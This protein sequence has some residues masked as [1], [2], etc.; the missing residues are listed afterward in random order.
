MHKALASIK[1]IM[2][3]PR[4]L[5]LMLF[6]AVFSGAAE[7]R[8]QAVFN[9]FGV[10]GAVVTASRDDQKFVT[11][12][13]SRGE[14]IFPDLADGVWDIKIEM[15]AFSPFQ[16]KVT[17]AP[18]STASQWELKL[19]PID[20]IPDI[21]RAPSLPPPQASAPASSIAQSSNSKKMPK[22]PTNTQTPY[23]RTEVKA[24]G[25]ASSQTNAEILPAPSTNSPSVD[26]SS[27]DLRQ[28]AAD[29]F[30][31]N[32]TANNSASSPFGLSRSFGNNRGLIR[33]LYN[34]S[35]GLTLGNSA[36]DARPYS[37]AGIH[38]DRP[39][40]NQIQGMFSYGGP[41]RIPHLISNGPNFYIGYQFTRN[42]NAQTQSGLMPTVAEREG[43]LSRQIMW[44]LPTTRF[45]QI[46]SVLR[47]SLC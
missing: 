27:E 14:Y 33:S 5:P 2:I 22:T 8:G 30:L 31:I 28:R 47:Q 46:E 20:Q 43:D 18:E 32:G 11:I 1:K 16:Q 44:L 40:Y 36:L 23:Q 9:G 12:T 10:P 37:L 25:A 21:Q 6:A 15:Q 45:Q 41:L 3:F 7:H 34:G 42:R 35:A 24:T 4:I 19:L 17:V 38:T 26:L 13:D 29:G 39:E